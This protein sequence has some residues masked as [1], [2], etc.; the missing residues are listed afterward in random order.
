MHDGVVG[1]REEGEVRGG[2]Q[3]YCQLALLRAN[4]PYQ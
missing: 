4:V 2:L 3:L 1:R